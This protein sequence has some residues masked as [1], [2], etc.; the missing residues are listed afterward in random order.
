MTQTSEQRRAD[1]AFE[2]VQAVR[3]ERWK[4][5]YGR[6]A[7]KLPILIRTCGPVAALEFLRTRDKDEGAHA[8][9]TH[10][11]RQ[12]RKANLLAPDKDSIGGLLERVRKAPLADY[13]RLTRELLATL[14]WHKRLSVSLLGVKAG[15]EGDRS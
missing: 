5:D 15:D 2:L 14:N 13:I 10:L 4:D 6:F 8:L 12:L 11:A 1:C 7:H 3:S 9:L